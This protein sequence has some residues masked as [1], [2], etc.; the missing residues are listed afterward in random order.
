VHAIAFGFLALIGAA[1]A[2]VV[3]P[4][5]LVVVWAVAPYVLALA[6]LGLGWAAWHSHDYWLLIPALIVG[7]PGGLWISIRH[8]EQATPV[9][10]ARRNSEMEKAAKAREWMKSM[11]ARMRTSDD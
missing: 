9:E 2:C 8:P 10:Q 1:L 7:L 4:V 3:V 5:V 6:G 11:E